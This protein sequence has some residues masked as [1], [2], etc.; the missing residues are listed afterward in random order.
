MLIQGQEKE[1]Q[2]QDKRVDPDMGL[3]E[4]VGEEGMEEGWDED[5]MGMEVTEVVRKRNR[6]W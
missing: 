3:E 4:L 5:H 1:V 6:G 2:R